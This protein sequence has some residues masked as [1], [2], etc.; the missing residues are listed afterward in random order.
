[1]ICAGCSRNAGRVR[2]IFDNDLPTMNLSTAGYARLLLVVV[3]GALTTWSLKTHP[4][5][6]SELVRRLPRCIGGLACFGFGIAL[7][8]L[9]DLGNP[10]WDVLHGGLAKKLDLPVGLV[11]NL[12][13]LVVLVLWIP[14]RERVGLGTV[15]NTLEIGLVLDL[16]L[17]VL[18]KPTNLGLRIAFAGAGLV[19]IAVG[20]GLYIGSGL[21]AGPRDGVMMGLRRFKLSVRTSRTIIEVTTMAIGYLLGGRLGAG[22]VFFMVGI[23]PL[24]QIALRHLSLPPLS[25]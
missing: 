14:L 7:F 2:S 5:P 15:L 1:M 8:F 16:T 6:V 9:A 19:I 10:P 22:T 13:G 12:V 18:T 3:L 17:E 24:V 11:V 20:S 4:I 25:E 23:G 21:G